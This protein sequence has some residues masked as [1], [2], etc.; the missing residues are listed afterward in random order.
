MSVYK[1]K[2]TLNGEGGG[3]GGGSELYTYYVETED[4]NE[5]VYTFTF[6]CDNPE[7]DSYTKLAQYLL[8]KGYYEHVEKRPYYTPI[9]GVSSNTG[10]SHIINGLYADPNYSEGVTSIFGSAI[11]ISSGE[12]SQGPIWLDPESDNFNITLITE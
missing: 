8:S 9:L 5:N 2:P 11:Y 6:Q 12:L 10:P 7:L 4:N 3:Q 1:M